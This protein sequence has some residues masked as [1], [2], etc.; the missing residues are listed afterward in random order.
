MNSSN[1]N[2]CQPARRVSLNP[3]A[4]SHG[5]TTL[6][7]NM[8]DCDVPRPTALLSQSSRFVDSRRAKP[9]VE[10]NFIHASVPRLVH[11]PVFSNDAVTMAV[12]IAR[13]RRAARF[14]TLVLGRHRRSQRPIV[15]SSPGRDWDL[16]TKRNGRL[17]TGWALCRLGFTTCWA[18]FGLNWSGK[19]HPN[20]RTKKSE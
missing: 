13:R 7:H 17:R 3:V 14:R 20:G 10:S 6:G 19:C 15:P 16:R 9:H 12:S 18:S 4:N 8:V 1:N 2:D 5:A 11:L